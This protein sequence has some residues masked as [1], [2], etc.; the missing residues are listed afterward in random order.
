M[1]TVIIIGKQNVQKHG[2]D[3]SGW[4]FS[5]R[6]FFGDV[7]RGGGFTRGNLMDGNFPWGSL[8]EGNINNGIYV[9]TI[10][11]K[12]FHLRCSIGFSI[13]LCFSS[14][15]SIELHWN[16]FPMMN[17]STYQTNLFNMRNFTYCKTIITEIAIQFL[18]NGFYAFIIY[19]RRELII[20]CRNSP[21]PNFPFLFSSQD[22]EI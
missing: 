20:N 1:I 15:P 21:H 3:Y 11:K 18:A 6:E 8:P 13:R 5:G 17:K 7:G 16:K 19:F 14:Q 22:Q 2:W 10:F 9:L 12:K 4:E